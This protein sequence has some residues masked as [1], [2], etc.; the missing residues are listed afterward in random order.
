MAPSVVPLFV[1]IA[2]LGTLAFPYSYAHDSPQDYL[3]SH[4]EARSLVGVGPVTWDNTLE[5]YA[6][7]YA[8]QRA[9]RDCS[10]VHSDGPYGENL[11]WSSGELSGKDS[12]AMWVEEKADY[13]YDTN[14]C[15]LG[16]MCGHYTQVVWESTTSIGCAKAACS[17]GQGTFVICSYSP[18]GNYIGEKPY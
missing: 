2:L 18:P 11:A 4:N 10:L 9:A 7:S 14:T 3:D 17:G 1:A 12:V 15:A 6:Q 5:S 8:N 13:D 16:K